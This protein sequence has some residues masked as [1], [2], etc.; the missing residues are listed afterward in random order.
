MVEPEKDSVI[1]LE[2]AKPIFWNP[3]GFALTISEDDVKEVRE[4]ACRRLVGGL[5]PS[6]HNI[7]PLQFNLVSL[8][9]LRA[10]DYTHFCSVSGQKSY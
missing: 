7:L 3:I 9:G 2:K 1:L 6:I 5:I 4:L 8:H 10:Q